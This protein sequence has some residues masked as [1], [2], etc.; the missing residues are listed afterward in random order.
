MRDHT[1]LR[2]DRSVAWAP[3]VARLKWGT[4]KGR[5]K[6]GDPERLKE[7]PELSWGALRIDVTALSACWMPRALD[8][9]SLPALKSIPSRVC[10]RLFI[11]SCICCG[12]CYHCSQQSTSHQL[13]AGEKSPRR[14]KGQKKK[15]RGWWCWGRL[16]LLRGWLDSGGRCRGDKGGRELSHKNVPPFL[17]EFFKKSRKDSEAKN[18]HINFHCK[19]KELLQWRITGLNVNI[20]T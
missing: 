14:E 6:H 9:N 4:S 17:F 10:L 20:M 15:K 13:G 11:L 5:E 16:W 8:P 18:I 1:I 3:W 2:G 19:V 7:E 12:C